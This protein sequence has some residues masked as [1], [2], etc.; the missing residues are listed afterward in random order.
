MDRVEQ[1]CLWHNNYMVP[2]GRPGGLAG[3][4]ARTF[5]PFGGP[6]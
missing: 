3:Q 4:R 5:F 1:F 6:N 2:V